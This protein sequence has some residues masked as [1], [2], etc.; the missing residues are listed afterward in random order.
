MAEWDRAFVEEVRRASFRLENSAKSAASWLKTFSTFWPA[1]ISS[2][3]PLTLPRY[4]CCSSKY[5]RLRFP[6]HLINRNIKSM[7]KRTIRDSRISRTRSMTMV[8]IT[9]TKLWISMVKLLFSA[10]EIVST[11]LVKRLMRSP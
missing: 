8:P 9:V 3:N 6:F 2:T 1:I 10:S 4:F 11:S 5:R 7:K